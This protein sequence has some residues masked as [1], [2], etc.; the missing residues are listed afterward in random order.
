MMDSGEPK[1]IGSSPGRYE[2][3]IEFGSPETA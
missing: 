1:S 3:P 2:A